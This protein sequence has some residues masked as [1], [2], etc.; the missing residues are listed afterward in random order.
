V[1]AI[2]L[3]RRAAVRDTRGHAAGVD[4]SKTMSFAKQKHECESETREDVTVTIDL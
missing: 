1:T 2:V 4:G 3:N